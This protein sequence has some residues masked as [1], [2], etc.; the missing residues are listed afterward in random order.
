MDI[1]VG[2]VKVAFIGILETLIAARVADN[3]TG[4]RFN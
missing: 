2:S 3:L 4:T 1:F